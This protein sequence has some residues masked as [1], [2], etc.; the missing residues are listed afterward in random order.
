MM[1]PIALT[2]IAL[3]FLVFLIGI[4]LIIKRMKLAGTVISL[5]VLL[6]DF[7]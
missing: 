4:R 3:G 6:R 7:V 5:L 2:A 1:N